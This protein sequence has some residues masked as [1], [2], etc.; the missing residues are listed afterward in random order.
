[1]TNLVSAIDKGN[2]SANRS[3]ELIKYDT[4]FV[5]QFDFNVATVD[6]ILTF[7]QQQVP[8][9]SPSRPSY[10]W[11]DCIANRKSQDYATYGWTN[12][13]YTYIIYLTG[14][15][16]LDYAIFKTASSIVDTFVL[17]EQWFW[18]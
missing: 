14:S 15:N 4:I 2:I 13:W 17:I 11:T 18:H 5:A 3:A 6:F 10:N 16:M 9:I 12:T 1:M 8:R 7:N